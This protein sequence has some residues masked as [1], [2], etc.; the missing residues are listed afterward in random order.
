MEIPYLFVSPFVTNS[1]I[2]ITH[3]IYMLVAFLNS[4]MVGSMCDIPNNVS[5]TKMTFYSCIWE[6]CPDIQCI[7][8]SLHECT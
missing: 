2:H 7:H 1:C 5:S 3:K 4:R 8:H 6:D